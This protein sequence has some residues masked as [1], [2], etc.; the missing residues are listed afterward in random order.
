LL[1]PRPLSPTDPHWAHTPSG[2]LFDMAMLV[3]LSLFYAGFD[4][5]L[6]DIAGVQVVRAA[7]LYFR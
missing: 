6:V 5:Q 2:W 4:R 1:E 7:D 3:A